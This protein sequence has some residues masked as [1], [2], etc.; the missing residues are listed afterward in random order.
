MGKKKI[1]IRPL[2][3]GSYRYSMGLHRCPL[4]RAFLRLRSIEML[5]LVDVPL[6]SYFFAGSSMFRAKRLPEERLSK[7][8]DTL[9]L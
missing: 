3:E 1:T 4:D 7:F 8:N 5:C 6:L 9:T 2:V